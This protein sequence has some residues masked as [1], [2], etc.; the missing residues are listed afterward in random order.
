MTALDG[1]SRLE[2]VD[3]IPKVLKLF[4][5]KEVSISRKSLAVMS[6]LADSGHT[7]VVTSAIE[8]KLKSEFD[9]GKKERLQQFLDGI[10]R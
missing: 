6:E 10:H 3:L 4:D 7:P 9:R 5:A 1:V 8:S 2:M